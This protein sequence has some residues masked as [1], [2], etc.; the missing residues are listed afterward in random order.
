MKKQKI[1]EIFNM[2]TVIGL[3]TAVSIVVGALLQ[4]VVLCL[5]IGAG[6]GVV[7]GTITKNRGEK[8]Q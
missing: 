5:F 1:S 2:G 3:S 6:I 7:I 4:N 8:A